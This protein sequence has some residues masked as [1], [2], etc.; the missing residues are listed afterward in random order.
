MNQLPPVAIDS[1]HSL[2]PGISEINTEEEERNR[3]GKIEV[4]SM[5]GTKLH[6][7]NSGS[8]FTNNES[9]GDLPSI[10]YSLSSVQMKITLRSDCNDF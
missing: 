4:G 3:G 6:G 1:I 7:L 10:N 2:R 8:Y 9:V 5:M